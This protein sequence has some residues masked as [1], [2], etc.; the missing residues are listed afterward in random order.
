MIDPKERKISKE[1]NTIR[2]ERVRKGQGCMKHRKQGPSPAV[3]YFQLK[4]ETNL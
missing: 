4:K 2:A 1:V 3:H